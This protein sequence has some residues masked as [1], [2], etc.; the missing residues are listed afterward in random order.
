MN[1]LTRKSLSRRAL[2]RGAGAAVALPLLESMI[3]AGVARAANAAPRLR[4]A[5]VYVPH[6]AVMSRFT[7]AL[8]GADFAFPDIIK[9]LEPFRDRLNVVSN[10]TLPLAYGQDAS[11]GAN[12]TRSSAV[13]LTGASPGVGAEARLGTSVDQLASRHFGQGTPLPSLELSIEDG[14]LS[15]G[16]GLSCAYRNTISWQG[17]T[18]PLPM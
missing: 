13:F 12:H 18:S 4:F 3:P 11:A 14:S 8:V 15:C 16:A 1:F 2:L 5:A 7:P 6:G 9:P 17:P 10:L